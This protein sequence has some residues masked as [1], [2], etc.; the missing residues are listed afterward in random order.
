MHKLRL[1]RQCPLTIYIVC[2]CQDGV[3]VSLPISFPSF[4][5]TSQS[6]RSYQRH[7]AQCDWTLHDYL[8]TRIWTNSLELIGVWDVCLT[9]EGAQQSTWVGSCM[10]DS[11]KNSHFG[12]NATETQGCRSTAEMETWKKDYA[13]AMQRRKHASFKWSWSES[14]KVGLMEARPGPY[15]SLIAISRH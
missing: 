6:R 10:M 12:L 11:V 3:G 4:E 2:D 8:I 1:L 15:E 7:V 9:D 5:R 14:R 13:R